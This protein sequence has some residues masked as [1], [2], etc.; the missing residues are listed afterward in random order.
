M[1]DLPAIRGQAAR[2]IITLQIKAN[3]LRT[4]VP[5]SFRLSQPSLVAARS[6]NP[7]IALQVR[8][9]RLMSPAL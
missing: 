7:L 8:G 9:A 4:I 2:R 1:S 5:P 3:Y 6:S